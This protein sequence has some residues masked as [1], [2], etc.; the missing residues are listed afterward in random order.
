M[1]PEELAR[2]WGRCDGAGE[3]GMPRVQN[4]E[5]QKGLEDK[6]GQLCDNHKTH[7]QL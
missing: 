7:R 2:T 5:R 6:L 4:T 1:T 3:K